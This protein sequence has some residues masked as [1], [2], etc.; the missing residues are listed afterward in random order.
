MA[1]TYEAGTLKAIGY[2]GK[3]QS[4]V[5]E[6]HSAGEATQIKLSP[7]RNRIK[8]DGQDLSYITVELTD[9]NGFCNP[10]A[11]NQVSFEIN[12]PGTIIAVGNANPVSLE[13]FQLPHRK[14]WHGRCMVVVKSIQT[15]VKL[16]SKLLLPG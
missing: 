1:S 8:S 14:G 15:P 16:S 5:A 12:G 4:A 11:E 7:D 6:L 13:S 2:T 3:K 9:N 10:K